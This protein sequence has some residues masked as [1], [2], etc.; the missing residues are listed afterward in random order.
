VRIAVL[1]EGGET[2]TALRESDM[3]DSEPRLVVPNLMDRRRNTRLA[4]WMA[5]VLGALGV[6]MVW[7]LLRSDAQVLLEQLSLP[8]GASDDS[9][10][11]VTP[12]DGSMPAIATRSFTVR[13]D[14]A[15]L[16]RFYFERCK[17]LGLA[18]PDASHRRTEPTLLCQRPRPGPG[19]VILLSTRCG[20]GT[21]AVFIEARVSIT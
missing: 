18:D 9:G 10:I 14:E 6:L 11:D 17:A 21:C 1:K 7:I 4:V 13:S 8:E 19:E 3:N 5:F 15:S 12:A 2:R 16:R 20:A